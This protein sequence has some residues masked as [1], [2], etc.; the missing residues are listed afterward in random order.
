MKLRYLGLLF[1]VRSGSLREL[2]LSE[3]GTA[4]VGHCGNRSVRSCRID[5][6]Q[7]QGGDGQG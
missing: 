7:H 6:G 4:A 1:F 5:R 2:P 3:K